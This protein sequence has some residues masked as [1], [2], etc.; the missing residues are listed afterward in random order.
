MWRKALILGL[1]IVFVGSIFIQPVLG[2]EYP[3]K[4]IEL[5]CPFPAGGSIDLYS[6]LVADRVRDI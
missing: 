2:K 3:T 6:R 4:P 1:S 5:L